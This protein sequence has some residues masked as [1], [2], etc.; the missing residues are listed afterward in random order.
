[1]SLTI[2]GAFPKCFSTV[3]TSWAWTMISWQRPG[4]AG[5]IYPW[6]LPHEVLDT[7]VV[8]PNLG[9]FPK[10]GQIDH[11]VSGCLV[12]GRV[13]EHQPIKQDDVF[14]RSFAARGEQHGEGYSVNASRSVAAQTSSRSVE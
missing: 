7:V 10:V 9:A 11:E 6:P 1:M 5:W 14:E 8:E 3:K 13:G 2:S 4:E 12:L